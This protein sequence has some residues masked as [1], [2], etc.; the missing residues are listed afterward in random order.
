[1][2]KTSFKFIGSLSFIAI[3]ISTAMSVAVISLIILTNFV[4]HSPLRHQSD[5]I[6]MMVLCLV[7]VES[8]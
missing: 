5:A 4:H 2:N 8:N 6:V 3:Y 1:M 7:L